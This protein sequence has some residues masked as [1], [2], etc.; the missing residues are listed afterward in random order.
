MEK[1]VRSSRDFSTSGGDTNNGAHT[2][3]LVTSLESV[4]HHANVTGSVE[5]EVEAA[6]GL[7]NEVINNALALGEILGV[8]KVGCIYPHELD[9]RE[10]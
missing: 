5:G 6:V 10:L 3:T 9:Q 1:N 7:L 8:D 2:P 4:S